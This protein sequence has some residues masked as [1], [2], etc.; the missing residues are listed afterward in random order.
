MVT[1]RKTPSRNRV[2]LTE[3][4]NE[5]RIYASSDPLPEPTRIAQ[6]AKI[7][8]LREKTAGISVES[9]VKKLTDT[10]LSVGK[11]IADVQATIA[12]Q[13]T[14]LAEIR[15]AIEEAK[16]DLETIYGKEVAAASL[17]QLVADFDAKKKELDERV[18]TF[19]ENW[20]KQKAIYANQEE[21][22]VEVEQTARQ[23]EQSDYVYHRDMERRGLTDKFN[24]QLQDDKR[25]ELIRKNDL[26]RSWAER[27][28]R[29]KAQEESVAQMKARIDG[30]PTEID[31]AVKKEVAIV[32]NSISREHKH[33]VE[34]L[35]KDFSAKETILGAQVE[36]LKT[37]LANA[38]DTI[39][40][41]S[42]QLNSAQEKVAKIASDA[43]NAA[44]GT[45]A[46]AEMRNI[47]NSGANNGAQKKS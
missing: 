4:M 25:I 10:G 30:L 11:A 24:Q 46:L 9:A 31:S 21:D 37:Q 6:E 47:V 40:N 20:E 8:E 19:Q 12:A 32:S 27:E 17:A 44:S 33:Q 29:L 22:R 41:L 38:H 5:V 35:T 45:Q 7:A 43:L 16:K 28:A 26:E 1:K 13:V 39:A 34:I 3:E 15:M 42:Q 2:E 18:S 36:N 23:R 14:E